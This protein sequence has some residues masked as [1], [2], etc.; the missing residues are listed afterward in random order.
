M[1]VKAAV[2]QMHSLL[3]QPRT[4]SHCLLLFIWMLVDR[5]K[6]VLLIRSGRGDCHLM[7]LCVQKLSVFL[8]VSVYLSGRAR[9]AVQGSLDL[10]T[11]KFKLKC[12]CLLHRSIHF[13]NRSSSVDSCVS[14]SGQSTLDTWPVHHKTHTH[15]L[16]HSLILSLTC[17]HCMYFDCVETRAP[18]QSVQLF[19]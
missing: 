8:S 18:A 14:V 7:C 5:E 19:H 6:L 3:H 12:C 4:G 15:S 16:T 11:R 13:S 2:F 10:R 1:H 9:A 17:Q